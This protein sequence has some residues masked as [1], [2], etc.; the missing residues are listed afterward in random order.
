MGYSLH[1]YINTMV[2]FYDVYYWSLI[3]HFIFFTSLR[4]ISV[5]YFSIKVLNIDI[6]ISG[7]YIYYIDEEKIESNS[8][9]RI[10]NLLI[11]SENIEYI[12]YYY[13]NIYRINSVSL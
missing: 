12:C 1:I 10:C 2:R 3:K 11:S 13:L 8:Y 7:D 5:D 4:A 9:L 6:N